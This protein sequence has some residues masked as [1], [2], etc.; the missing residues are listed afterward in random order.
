[1]GRSCGTSTSVAPEDWRGANGLNVHGD[2]HH[3]SEHPGVKSFLANVHFKVLPQ[4]MQLKRSMEIGDPNVFFIN[5]EFVDDEVVLEIVNANSAGELILDE[6]INWECT[7]NELYTRTKAWEN[8]IQYNQLKKIIGP[9]PHHRTSGIT[10][11]DLTN[12][13]EELGDSRITHNRGVVQ[14][15]L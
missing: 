6:V 1:M 5:T 11:S 2:L 3:T 13:L 10:I 4:W 15:P 12:R 7:I 8:Y 9:P 14:G